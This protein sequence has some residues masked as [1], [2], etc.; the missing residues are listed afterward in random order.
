M[1]A[2][3]A[4][5][6]QMMCVWLP[7]A[8]RL[9]C[10][11]LTPRTASNCDHGRTAYSG[12]ITAYILPTGPPLKPSLNQDRRRSPARE[13]AAASAFLAIFASRSMASTRHLIPCCYGLQRG[14]GGKVRIR[15][16]CI[17]DTHCSM[18]STRSSSSLTV[19]S[20]FSSVS[21][22]GLINRTER[23]T[24][25]EAIRISIV[26]D[27]LVLALCQ[28]RCKL[29]ASVRVARSDLRTGRQCAL[30]RSSRA[31]SPSIASSMVADIWH[32]TSVARPQHDGG[33]ISSASVL[34]DR[35]VLRAMTF[36]HSETELESQHVQVKI[37]PIEPSLV[38]NTAAGGFGG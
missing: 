27:R 21:V 32:R 13:D 18:P 37:E 25:E 23:F 6:V 20:L 10:S 19:R 8:L 38:Q 17:V 30:P 24:A 36:P 26:C 28:V 5:D 15:R 9:C 3:V 11:R 34:L 7:I 35:H 29:V 33:P 14:L 31:S 12:L 16:R 4:R 22:S 2:F 1:V